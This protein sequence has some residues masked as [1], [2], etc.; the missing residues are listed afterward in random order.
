MDSSVATTLYVLAVQVDRR[1]PGPAEAVRRRWTF[2]CIDSRDD[3][4]FGLAS[5]ASEARA[6]ANASCGGTAKRRRRGGS[7]DKP[8]DQGDG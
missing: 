7:S 4:I 8:E 1:L 3:A 5:W 6:W 2:A